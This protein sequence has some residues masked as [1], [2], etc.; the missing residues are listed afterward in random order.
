MGKENLVTYS[1]TQTKLLPPPYE[2]NCKHYPIDNTGKQDM[3][4]DCINKCVID[5]LEDEFKLGC[6]WSERNVRLTRLENMLRYRYLP[7]CDTKSSRYSGGL[8]TVVSRTQLMLISMCQDKC[9]KNCLERFYNFE[10]RAQSDWRQSNGTFF[11]ITLE[12]NRFP[13][14]TTE[15][16]PILDWITLVSNIGGLLGMWLGFSIFSLHR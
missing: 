4:S 8:Y 12:H 10:V 1:E 5:K 2:T 7:F 9:P 13:D 16:K 15:H 14:Q 11:T 6:I 3:R